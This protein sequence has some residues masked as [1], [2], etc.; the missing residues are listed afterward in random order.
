[1]DGER[2]EGVG[3]GKDGK[4]VDIGLIFNFMFIF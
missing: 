3:G 2:K 4:K 1:M